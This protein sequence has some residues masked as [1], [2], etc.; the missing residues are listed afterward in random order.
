MITSTGIRVAP[1]N[2]NCPSELD[3]AIAMCRITRYAGAIW[4]PLAAHSI[5][6]AELVLT[7]SH[8]L[9]DW[10]CGLLHDAHE[11]VT[12]EITRPWKPREMKTFEKDLNYRLEK[13]FQVFGLEG[14]QIKEADVRALVCEATVLNLPGF[15]DIYGVRHPEIQHPNPLELLIAKAVLCSPWILPPETDG[16]RIRAITLSEALKMI[17]VGNFSSARDI[18]FR[19]MPSLPEIEIKG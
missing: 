14:K 17:R 15:W 19:T 8:S 11:T 3:V 2:Q 16:W 7:M 18:I 6:V 12:G 4:C 13:H 9:F 10:A 1:D 5:L